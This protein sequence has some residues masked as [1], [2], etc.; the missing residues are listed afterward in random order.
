[1]YAE[2]SAGRDGTAITNRANDRN[3][4]VGEAFHA[5]GTNRASPVVAELVYLRGDSSKR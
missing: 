4:S 2:K 5:I 3:K 1:M